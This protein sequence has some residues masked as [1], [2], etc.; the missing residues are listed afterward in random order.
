MKKLQTVSESLKSRIVNEGHVDTDKMMYADSIAKALQ[1]NK[2][3]LGNVWTTDIVDA[4]SDYVSGNGGG[5]IKYTRPA[6]PDEIQ[7]SVTIDNRK[8]P[9]PEL[10]DQGMPIENTGDNVAEDTGD[11]TIC[12]S[13][14]D[15][16]I[17]DHTFPNQ[18]LCGLSQLVVDYVASIV[19]EYHSKQKVEVTNEARSKKLNESSISPSDLAVVATGM[20]G[21]IGSSVGIA[22]LME[23]LK[24]H[25]PKIYNALSKAGSAAS[26]SRTKGVNESSISPS[27]LAI[28]ASGMAGIIGSSV[29][30]AGLMEYLK[31]HHPKIYAALSKAGSA[32]TDSRAR[33]VN[34]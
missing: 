8:S 2:S 26:T 23:Y 16:K 7:Y 28:V 12:V 1:K 4:G 10:D 19:S 33:G 6:T 34:K 20:A 30:I 3:E 11:V 31:E 25:Y 21:I 22:G 14:N 24:E 27:D 17:E 13:I 15:N 5:T 32:A 9:E 29:G 18:S